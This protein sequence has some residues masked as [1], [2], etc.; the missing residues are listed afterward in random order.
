VE[1]GTA[2][3]SPFADQSKVSWAF[4]RFWRSRIR[5]AWRDLRAP[6]V[7]L[8]AV[9]VLVLG[10]IGYTDSDED[11]NGWE[12]FFKSF[13]L[14]AFAGGDVSSGDPATLNIARV[15]APLL[16]GYAAIRG[17][18]ALSREQ[19][20][21]VGF[22]IFRRG[23][24]VVAG[25]GDVGFR[26]ADV[27]NK[28]GA[29][30]IAIDRDV[31]RASAEA[32]RVRGISVLGGDATDPGT[33]RAACVHRAAHLIVAPGT[34]AA[35]IDVIAAAREIAVGR[36]GAA[37]QIFAHIE[38]PVLWRALRARALSLNQ[39]GEPRVEP[40]NLYE[41]AGRLILAEHPPF[42]LSEAGGRSGPAMLI[43]SDQPLGEILVVNAARVWRNERGGD[44]ARITIELAAPD[45][46]QACQGILARNP[47]L[48][49][50]CALE[51][52]PLELGSSEL[53]SDRAA[54]AT[55]AYV[56]LGDE[57]DGLA[58]SLMI[59]DSGPEPPR[60]V[61][62]INDDSLGV[63]SVAEDGGAGEID[64]FGV[65]SR[66]LTPGFL[67]T[68]LTDLIA[69][70]MHES[71][72]RDQ[73]ALGKTPDEL[74]YLKPWHELDD[75][76]KRKSRDF[77]A[78]VRN[79]LN[80]VKRVAVPTALVDLDRDGARFD[81]AE[82]EQLAELEHERWMRD[83]AAA[84]GAYGPK[85]DDDARLHPSMKPWVELSE[86][87]RDKDRAAVRDLPQMLAEAGFAIER[88]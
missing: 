43:V 57:A 79:K 46:E 3:E 44:R 48:E 10:T 19:L 23:H 65:L 81:P 16:V 37:L 11:L 34:D 85:R 63:A 86:G 24:V 78:D 8:A 59:A 6:L 75:E 51:P 40:F 32:C 35:A 4:R 21:L 73:L 22:R 54:K 87:E 47:A 56:A 30:V 7:L 74:P 45:A 49:S 2:A 42:E 31:T 66:T 55:T 88:V 80:A 70:A 64:I 68:G 58:G 71:Y 25:L 12:A 39:P 60:V 27:L 83:E 50:V 53:R 33:L 84:G 61:L 17:L 52:W 72:V 5:P 13:Q 20:R 67:L 28:E 26:L 36:T 69:Q 14:F 76:G 62:V 15:L 77:A 82:V 41:A 18:L 9:G 1:K 29:R 38:G